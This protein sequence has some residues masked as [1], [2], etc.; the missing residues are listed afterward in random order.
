[1]L[2]EHLGYVADAVRLEHFRAAIGKSVR[3]GDRVADLGCGSGILGLLCLQ[4]GAAHVDFVDESEM[5]EVARESVARAGLH[6]RASFV[7]GRSQHVELPQQVDAVVCDHIGHFGFDYGIVELLR[8]AKRRFLK[9]GGAMIPARIDLQLAA[10]E[11]EK[12]RQLAEGWGA[13]GVPGEFH[14]LSG[15]ARNTK[16]NVNLPREDILSAPV[17]SGTIDF[18]GDERGF[19]SCCAEL[20]ATRAG[21]MHGLGGWFDCELAPGVRMTNSPLAE[22]KIDRAQAFLPIGEAVEVKE[23]DAVK[24]TLMLRPAESLIA[25][26]AEFPAN[27]R[28]FTHSNWQGMLLSREDLLRSNPARVPLLGRAGLA[29]RT[30]LGYC[31]GRRTAREIVQVILKEHPGLFPSAEEL[32]GFV[33]RVLARD[34]E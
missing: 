1:M 31:D 17:A 33:A 9:P 20:R 18:L 14:W 19:L 11:S 15:Q 21:T 7:R 3:T 4:A 10:V 6:N 22:K 16:F 12:F 34:T 13:T 23:G 24:A 5:I 30:V 29:R 27:G 28:R 25:W 8:D 26:T 32:S 2:Q